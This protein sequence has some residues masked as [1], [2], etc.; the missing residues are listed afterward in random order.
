MTSTVTLAMPLCL[1]S[2]LGC[3]RKLGSYTTC[4][5]LPHVSVPV[6]SYLVGCYCSWYSL[7]SK[8]A[9]R[10]C[11]TQHLVNDTGG[12][13]GWLLCRL[14]EGEHQ[15]LARPTHLQLDL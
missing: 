4:V 11:D 2:V 14:L 8:Q 3:L 12:A 1:S 15:H 13:A 9:Q 10:Q 7:L 6:C 5:L